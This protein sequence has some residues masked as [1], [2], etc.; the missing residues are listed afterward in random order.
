MSVDGGP[1]P[2]GAIEGGYSGP[3]S[4]NPYYI[5]RVLATDG[6]YYPGKG[7]F[8]QGKTL[9]RYCYDNKETIS[10]K[11]EILCLFDG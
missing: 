1:L 8:W 10:Y 2:A 3:K 11:C 5:G 6:K 7:E 4:E 9:T